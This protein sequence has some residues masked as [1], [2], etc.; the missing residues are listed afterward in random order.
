PGVKADMQHAAGAFDHPLPYDNPDIARPSCHGF[1]GLRES[2]LFD[3]A[4]ETWRHAGKMTRGRWYPSTLMLADGR[5]LAMHRFDDVGADTCL[6]IGN[7]TVETFDPSTERWSD[8]V[9]Y[10]ADWPDERYPYLHLLPSGDAFY[11]GPSAVTR[12]FHP[13]SLA[14]VGTTMATTR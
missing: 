14:T 8:P 2:F 9:S 13:D 10:P 11:A 1:L 12:V 7:R 4:T 3:P 5:V 6:A